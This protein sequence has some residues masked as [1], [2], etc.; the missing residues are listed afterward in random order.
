MKTRFLTLI[1]VIVL[2]GAALRF[3]Q[4]GKTPISLEWD[5]VALGY[6]AYSILQTGRD[7]F[8][9][10]FPI[11]FRSLD[12]WKPP[13]YVYSAV[14]AVAIFGLT[15]FA[16]R[17]PS[18]VFGTAAVFLTY[19]LVLEL[20]AQRRSWEK[21][22]LALL[23]ALFLAVSPWHL[24]FSRAAFETNLSVTV[25]L[26]AL[27]TFLKGISGNKKLFILSAFFFGLSFFSYHSTRVVTPLI[28][29]SL[30]VI[31]RRQLPD[32]K[33]ILASLGLYL[34]FVIFFLPIATSPDAQ[35]RFLVTNDLNIGKY[36]EDAAK[37][38][39]ND[40]NIGQEMAGKIFHNRRIAMINYENFQKVLRN[41]F[42]HFSPKFLV[43]EGDATLHHA[44]G[45]GMI[46][47]FDFLLL[48][49]GVIFYLTR[50]RSRRS[51]I[52]PL[53]LLFAPIPAAITWQ[54]P[55]SVRSEIILPTLQIFTA[56]G[57]VGILTILRREWRVLAW[58]FGIIIL[59]FFIFGVGS[60]LHQYYGHTNVE[61]SKYWLYGRK[62]A[63]IYTES[64]KV[65]YDK[66]LVSLKVDMPYI[67]W[68][69]YTKYPPQK[70][71][72]EGGIVSGGFADERNHFD[73]YEFRNF[74]YKSL[75]ES[76]QKLLLVGTPKDFPPDARILKTI[77]YLDGSVA[78]IIAENR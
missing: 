67:F 35:I 43:V 30:L 26:L 69:F 55:H 25:T 48:V 73:K 10:W 39:N 36:Q 71:L 23:S 9:T 77:Y 54:A 15:E 53:W 7:Q 58:V 3:F 65:N 20:F 60:Y 49:L 37:L 72:S 46:Y 64:A 52:L 74:D 1:I 45:F 19:L 28:L 50:Y 5:E 57:L 61:L 31:F 42:V 66:V 6:D 33:T 41:Y 75:T 38:I 78:L 4:L 27:V 70:N 8:G 51:L 13:L 21:Q 16:T 32:R 22:L 47:Y 24:Q 68:L 63:A 14:P 76:P 56:I 59:P 2:L 40:K 44:P 17:F 62:D 34:F 12:D 11:N 18:A 29:L